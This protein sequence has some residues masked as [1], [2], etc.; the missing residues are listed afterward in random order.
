MLGYL[1]GS[2]RPLKALTCSAGGSWSPQDVSGALE[3]GWFLPEVTHA[4]GSFSFLPC[5]SITII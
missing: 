1:R 5:S 3:L 2:D 4:F